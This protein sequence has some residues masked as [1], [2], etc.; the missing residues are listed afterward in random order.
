MPIVNTL[1]GFQDS[2]L[3]HM[4]SAVEEKSQNFIDEETGTNQTERR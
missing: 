1:Y 3:N 4:T 2:E